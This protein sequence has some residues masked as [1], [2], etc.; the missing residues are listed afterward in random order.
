MISVRCVLTI[1][2]RIKPLPVP[3]KVALRLR[4]LSVSHSMTELTTYLGGGGGLSSGGG[5]GLQA[6]HSTLQLNQLST[7]SQV[8]LWGSSHR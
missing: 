4:L 1:S 6:H 5:L 3:T 8:L 2:V 7:L